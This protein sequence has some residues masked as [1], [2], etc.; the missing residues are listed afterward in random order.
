LTIAPITTNPTRQEK[1][2]VP[3]RTRVSFRAITFRGA[4]VLAA[5]AI[6]LSACGGGIGYSSHAS[7]GTTTPAKSA[8]PTSLASPAAAVTVKVASAGI[9]QVLVDTDGMTLYRFDKDKGTTS[10]CNGACAM[11]WPALSVA[12]APAGSADLGGSLGVTT[13]ADGTT[14]VTYQGHPLYRYAGDQQPG[15]TN[16]DGIGGIW[17]AVR[18][19][20]AQAAPDAPA[21]QA[22]PTT[23]TTTGSSS[24]Y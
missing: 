6:A 2:P 5:G 9:G 13:R 11:T 16:G 3:M 23:A 17:H 24:S 4:G 15:D 1:E 8:S 22:A 20:A 18:P 12:G 7:A 10:S 21:A 14:Q 19:G